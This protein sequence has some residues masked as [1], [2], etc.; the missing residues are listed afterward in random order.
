MLACSSA[1]LAS[2][3]Y[4]HYYYAHKN[5][6]PRLP[7]P[8]ATSDRDSWRAKRAPRHGSVNGPEQVLPRALVASICA[9]RLLHTC[10]MSQCCDRLTKLPGG[11]ALAL[12]S[13]GL[14]CHC[15]SCCVLLGRT[16]PSRTTSL[17]TNKLAVCAL[18]VCGS[19]SLTL[20]DINI[21]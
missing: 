13:S 20:N 11:R 16:F 17:C 12:D 9:A 1:I 3:S 15:G 2:E 14:V 10:C 8:T 5:I 6:N 19:H 7:P 18:S 4:L 21:Q